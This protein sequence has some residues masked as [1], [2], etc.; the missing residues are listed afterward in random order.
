MATPENPPFQIDVE[1]LEAWLDEGFNSYAE[2]ACLAAVMR[3]R[4]A[5]EIHLYKPWL[6][7]RLALLFRPF[8]LRLDRPGWRFRNR[9][10]YFLASYGKTA[11]ALKTLE[12]LAGRE[13]F[14]RAMRAYAE[15]FR[16][17]HP[18]GDDFFCVFNEAA[19]ADYGRCWRFARSG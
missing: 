2:A 7:G 12:G 4:L 14:A 13:T 11:I 5:P 6:I 1:Q 8:P 17:R 15:R 19:G 10:D 16:Y 18:G 9:T 3:D